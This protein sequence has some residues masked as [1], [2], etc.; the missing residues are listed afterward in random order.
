ME[1]TTD[2]IQQVWEKG[3]AYT[4]ISMD[5]WREDECGA[6]MSRADYGRA[7]SEFGWKIVKVSAERAD[8]PDNLRPFHYRNDYDIAG[9]KAKRRVTADR[10]SLAIFERTFEP[11]NRDA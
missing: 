2:V 9:H 7:D 3:R 11:H 4:D 8:T 10:S 5:A 6:W 1:Y